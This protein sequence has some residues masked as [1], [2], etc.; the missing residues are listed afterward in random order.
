[1]RRKGGENKWKGLLESFSYESRYETARH[2][3]EYT[4][5]LSFFNYYYFIKPD[6]IL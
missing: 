2:Y 6:N 5:S 3:R 1:M 4:L